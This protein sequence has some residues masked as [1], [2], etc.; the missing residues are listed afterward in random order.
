[1][2]LNAKGRKEEML[3]DSFKHKIWLSSPTMHCDELKYVTKAYE[4]NWMSKV[5]KKY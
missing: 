4:T 1:M 2:I 3:I 5:G